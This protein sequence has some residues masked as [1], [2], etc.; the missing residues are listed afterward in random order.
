MTTAY[1]IIVLGFLGLFS[2]YALK[3]SFPKH[4]HKINFGVCCMV[5]ACVLGALFL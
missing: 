3:I 5:G 1:W 4:R 2:G